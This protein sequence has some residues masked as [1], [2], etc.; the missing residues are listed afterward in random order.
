MKNEKNYV[1]FPEVWPILKHFAGVFR[2][3][4]KPS[5]C[6]F[7]HLLKSGNENIFPIPTRQCSQLEHH[8]YHWPR[9][10]IDPHILENHWPFPNNI[11]R[12]K[13][14]HWP[15]KNHINPICKIIDFF[16]NN[17]WQLLD[18]LDKMSHLWHCLLF[19]NWFLKATTI[20]KKEMSKKCN[21]FCQAWKCYKVQS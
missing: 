1:G 2:W 21:A 15:F 8:D 11:K 20:Y 7:F 9:K 14:N 17:D 19:K 10:I 13:E 6:I 5:I 12:S 16:Q 18:C 4:H 3:A